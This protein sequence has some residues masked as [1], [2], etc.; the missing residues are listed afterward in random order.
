VILYDSIDT[1]ED[2]LEWIHQIPV[3]FDL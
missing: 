1:Q 3:K 2:P